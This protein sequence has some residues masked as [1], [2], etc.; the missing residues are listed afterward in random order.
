MFLHE[1]K[2]LGIEEL[3]LIF[4]PEADQPTAENL[5]PLT[6]ICANYSSKFVRSH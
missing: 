6:L 5:K 1:H 4:P 3:L 2:F